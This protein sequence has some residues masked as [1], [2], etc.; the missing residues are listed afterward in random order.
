[1]T[2]FEKLV[3]DKVN[4]IP[5]GC[6]TT[7]GL[8][9]KA[10][11][12]PRAARAVGNA[13]NHNPVLVKVPCHRVVLASGRVGGYAKGELEKIRLLK[14]EGITINNKKIDDFKKYLF[15]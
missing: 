15:K 11:G 1:M 4:T 9:A 7:Y 12:K 14:R 2:E 13:L 5:K 10:I 3:F 6:V 8:L